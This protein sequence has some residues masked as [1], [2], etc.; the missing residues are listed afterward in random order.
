[1]FLKE[2]KK[3]VKCTRLNK[4]LGI[5]FKYFSFFFFSFLVFSFLVGV[6]IKA[7]SKAYLLT[8]TQRPRPVR[9]NSGEKHLCAMNVF[10]CG[11]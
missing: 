1:M 3:K 10:S 4:P 7:R 11:T 2:E 9:V 5:S 8:N 6:E